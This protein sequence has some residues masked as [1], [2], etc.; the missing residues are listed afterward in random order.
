MSVPG[1]PSYFKRTSDIEEAPYGVCFQC[2]ETNH[3][4]NNLLLSRMLNNML[5]KL[6]MQNP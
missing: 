5:Y 2:G 1:N 3:L 6:N 4:V